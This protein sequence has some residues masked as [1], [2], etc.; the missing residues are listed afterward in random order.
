M[1]TA[2]THGLSFDSAQ[3]RPFPPCADCT[4]HAVRNRPSAP[5]ARAVVF[6]FSPSPPTPRPAHTSNSTLLDRAALGSRRLHPDPDP[7]V[8]QGASIGFDVLD[9][10]ANNPSPRDPSSCARPPPP[11]DTMP[12]RRLLARAHGRRTRLAIFRSGAECVSERPLCAIGFSPSPSLGGPHPSTHLPPPL[13]SP[14]KTNRRRHRDVR[15]SRRWTSSAGRRRIEEEDLLST[16][17]RPAQTDGSVGLV[18][19]DGTV[20]LPVTPRWR[21]R[22]GRTMNRGPADTWPRPSGGVGS[23]GGEPCLATAA[24]FRSA[25]R[26]RARASITRSG[27]V[28]QDVRQGDVEQQPAVAPP[29]T[30]RDSQVRRRREEAEEEGRTAGRRRPLGAGGPQRPRRRRARLAEP[31]GQRRDARDRR[32]PGRTE[33]AEAGA[34][35]RA[36]SE[37]RARGRGV[38]LLARESPAGGAASVSHRGSRL[39]RR[40]RG[41]PDQ[42]RGR[43]GEAGRVGGAEA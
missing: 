8:H 28:P 21:A 22:G 16:K 3:M 6:F 32:L 30:E 18:A 5:R 40:G 25:T 31:P 38:A 2:S 37:A 9:S 33:P 12:I 13:A 42:R 20:S 17:P 14:R 39:A 23:G 36:G 27:A 11:S 15:P 43:G 7:A 34:R 35:G 1:H 26:R 29:A 10:A 19:D 4:S 41:D 24:L